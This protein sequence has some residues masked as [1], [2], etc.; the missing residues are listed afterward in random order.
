MGKLYLRT[1]Q[2][3]QVYFMINLDLVGNKQGLHYRNT[4]NFFVYF[5]VNVGLC[6]I[7]KSESLS[8]IFTY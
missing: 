6:L 4:F 2:E 1:D 8:F 5:W 7:R 3:I